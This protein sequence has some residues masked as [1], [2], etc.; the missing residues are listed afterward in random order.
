MTNEVMTDDEL[1]TD[2]EIRNELD[3]DGACF[4]IRASAFLRPSS[5]ELRHS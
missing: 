5:F 3:A 4:V 2:D 1:I